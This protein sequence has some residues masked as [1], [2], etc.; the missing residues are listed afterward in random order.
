[1]Y[2]ILPYTK[3]KAKQL[4][5]I[6]KPSTRKG[7][8]LDVYNKKGEYLASVGAEGY[9]DYATYKKYFGKEI[10][11]QKRKLYKKRHNKDRKVKYTPGYFADQLLW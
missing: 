11:E 6:V 1:M 9:L 5:V 2:E 8:K 10:A 4:N 7:K 3:A